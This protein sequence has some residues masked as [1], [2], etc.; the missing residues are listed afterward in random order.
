MNPSRIGILGGGQLALMLADAASKMGRRPVV[1]AENA[2]SPAALT[3]TDSVLGSLSDEAS[4]E[5]FFSQV[6]QVVFENEFVD[7]ELL[8]RVSRKI[9]HRKIPIQF[10]P[11]LSVIQK[12]Q[13]KLEQKKIL[14][15]LG[16]PTAGFTV[17]DLKDKLR[18][19]LDCLLERWGGSCVLKWAKMGYDGKGVLVVDRLSEGLSVTEA[20][21]EAFCSEALK[22]KSAVY[23]ERKIKFKRELALVSVFSLKGEFLAYP[24]VISEQVHGICSRV[25]GPATQLGV[26]NE[27]ENRARR[28]A[29]IIAEKSNLRGAFAVE[30]F[31]TIEGDLWVNEI[32][33]RVHNSGHYTQDACS[34]DQFENH[35]RAVLDLPLGEVSYR[36]CF[37][38]L[39]LLGPE[40]ET[41]LEGLDDLPTPSARS[42]LHWYHKP[43][44]RPGRK[45]GHLNGVGQSISDLE[46]LW[47]ELIQVHRDWLRKMRL[48]K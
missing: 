10:Y 26:S 43:E 34:T 44:T 16:I 30:F 22:K 46:D 14:T 5:S 7:C 20:K 1:L 36:P 9:A 48:K 23:G 40:F 33:P 38:M 28:F 35:W 47:D 29:Q 32:A 27:I 17:L 25:S 42:H 19:Q 24:L 18:P 2:L 31:E 6:D 15:D 11:D 45:L 4:L 12:F 21:I 3:Y 37:A 13:D 39:N 41:Q 8:R